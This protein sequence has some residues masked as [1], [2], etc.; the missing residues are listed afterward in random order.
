[1][2][3]ANILLMS[4]FSICSFFCFISCNQHRSKAKP[5]EQPAPQVRQEEELVVKSKP[6][7]ANVT[8]SDGG[9]CVTPCTILK[10]RQQ[11]FSVTVQKEG[12]LPTTRKIKSVP[13]HSRLNKGSQSSEYDQTKLGIRYLSPNPLTVELDPAWKK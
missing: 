1:M 4:I 3:S 5:Q 13:L 12:Y 9:S 11:D 8:F 7:G 10:K 6:S 2:R